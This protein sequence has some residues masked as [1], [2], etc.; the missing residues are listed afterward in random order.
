MTDSVHSS[1][2]SSPVPVSDTA[3]EVEERLILAFRGMQPRDK[4][5]RVLDLNRACEEMA[6]ARLRQQYGPTL[7]PRELAL[8]LASLHLDRRSMIEAFGWDPE[9]QG[10]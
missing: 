9:V 4:L 3:P 5:A 7:S 2:R 6:A 1:G 8:R 10:Y